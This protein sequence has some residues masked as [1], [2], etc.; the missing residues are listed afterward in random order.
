MPELFFSAC[1]ILLHTKQ[2]EKLLHSGGNRTDLDLWLASNSVSG[3]SHC[4]HASQCGNTQSN[5]C[6]IKLRSQYT[7]ERF[8][9][10]EK[11]SQI[12]TV[13]GVHATRAGAKFFSTISG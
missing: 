9:N 8:E 3:H 11:K 12:L 10:S 1:Y 7:P 13:A 6:E 2:A 4:G 5:C